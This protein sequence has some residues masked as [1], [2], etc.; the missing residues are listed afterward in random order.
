M[1][2][3]VAAIVVAILAI[4]IVTAL[5]RRRAVPV[6]LS[7]QPSSPAPAWT[8]DEFAGLSEAARCDLVF[9]LQELPGDERTSTLVGALDDPSETVAL[10]AA[11][12]LTARGERAQVDRYFEERPG[13][14]SDRL[15][16]DLSLLS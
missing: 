6:T 8:G 12:A 11:K 9:A 7:Q 14:R 1:I 15:R 13:A 3:A 4:A 16:N 5:G 10:A 2:A